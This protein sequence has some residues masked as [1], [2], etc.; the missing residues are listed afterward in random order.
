MRLPARYLILALLSL[1][2]Y[3]L[4]RTYAPLIRTTF[5]QLT[6]KVPAFTSLPAITIGNSAS[7]AR[8]MSSE[9]F[10]KVSRRC[11]VVV[12]LRWNNC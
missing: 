3:M 6:C 5:R 11:G 4:P 12:L 10:P 1:S 7:S 8:Q 2:L 9:S